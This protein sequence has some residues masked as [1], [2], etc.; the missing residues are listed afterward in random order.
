MKTKLTKIEKLVLVASLCLVAMMMGAGYIKQTKPKEKYVSTLEQNKTI[1]GNEVSLKNKEFHMKK[2]GKLDTS[3]ENYFYCSS[4]QAEQINIEFDKID[5]TK[6][7][8]YKLSG[9]YKDKKFKFSIVVDESDNP[10][11]QAEKTSFKYII[12]QYS[13]VE[14]IKQIIGATAIDKNGNDLTN[15]IIGF[16]TQFPSE[17]G[18]HT[19]YLNVSDIQGNTGFLQI[20]IDFK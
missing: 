3:I 6:V 18:E 7:G 5:P 12:G 17:K 1:V 16:P 9:K 2:N 13:N 20:D 15:D 19:Y 14:E 8:T 4:K 10:M 11:I